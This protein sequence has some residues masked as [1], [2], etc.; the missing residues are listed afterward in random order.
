M[1]FI[2]LLVS[3]F[4]SNSRVSAAVSPVQLKCENRPHPL[5][6]DIAAPRLSWQLTSD[7]RNVHQSAF[8]V[9]VASSPAL[10]AKN[11]G[12]LWNSGQVKSNQNLWVPYA[13]KPLHSAQQ[14]FW[15][16][17]SWDSNARVS[18]WSV[19]GQWT[20][21]LLASTDW[22]AKWITAPSSASVTRKTIGYHAGETKQQ[23]DLK[24]VQVDLGK[25]LAIQT[26]RLH[27]MNHAD[28]AGFGFPL[29]F[30]VEAANNADF[31]NAT[32][33]ADQT[34]TDF[35]NPGTTP[36]GFDGKGVVARFVRVTVPKLAPHPNGVNFAFALSQLEVVS[37]G[38]NV[39]LDAPVLAKDSVENYGWG[40][41]A[42]TDGTLNSSANEAPKKN[43]TSVLLRKELNIKVGLRRA[44]VYVCGL[45][46]YEMTLNGAKV[47]T[48]L[49]APGWTKYDKTCLYDTHDITSQLKM[50]SNAVGLFLG[51]GM[52]NVT[53]GRYS[54]FT[55][56]FGPLKAIAQIRLEYIDGTIQT[57]GTDETWRV[58]PG[59]VTFGDPY[60]G[61]DYDARL[62]PRGWNQPGFKAVDWVPALVADGPGGTLKCL[63]VANPPIRAFDVFKPVGT[64]IISPSVTVYDMGQNASIIPRLVVKGAAGTTVRLIPGESVHA[65]GTVDQS[66]SGGPSYWQY[67]LA[68]NGNET[69]FSPFFYRGC[70]YLQVETSAPTGVALPVVESLANVFV[71][72]DSPPIGS[73]S[74][75][76]PLFNRIFPLVKWAQMSNMV[77]VM[78]DCPHRE[79]L[80]WLEED[81]LNG[82]ALRYNFDMSAMFSKMMNDIADSQQPNGFVPTTAPEYPVFG[83]DFRDSPEWSSALLLV[84]QQQLEFNGDAQL[85]DKYYDEMKRYVAYLDSRAHDH[86]VEFGLGDWYDIGPGEPGYSKLTPK[87]LTATAFYFQDALILSQTAKRRGLADEATKYQQLAQQIRVAFNAKF[88]N[89]ATNQYGSGSQA[90]NS[91]PL[92]MGIAD[93]ANRAAILENLVKDVQ[94]KGLTAGDV[95][96]RYLLRALADGGRS[97]V[98]YAMNNQSDKPGYGMQLAKGATSLTEAWDAHASSSQNHFMLGQINE[99]FYHDLAG[100]QSD[101]TG[102]GFQK[103]II[104]PAVVGDLTHAQATYNSPYG[105]IISNWKRTDGKLILNISIPANTTATVYL[106]TKDAAHITESGKAVGQSV[107]VKFL[108]MEKS[109]AVYVVGSGTYDFA[110]PDN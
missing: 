101:P 107:G 90:S 34:A 28:V 97:D 39:A 13:G 69:Y 35:A 2:F 94:Q 52:Y 9:L 7:A 16:V 37:G 22:Q 110:A 23:D 20:M 103:I 45:G 82:P 3:L 57:I 75:S 36:V 79:K 29:R 14:V 46:Q 62:E 72:A 43:Y 102:P 21:G 24:W 27:P 53:G 47:G 67:T 68:G 96:Y 1:K 87:G 25:P 41:A 73:F 88:F 109:S 85:L 65:N 77:S 38:K 50:G 60:G 26:V 95:G 84:A 48:D 59:P 4:M 98:I 42:L 6:V 5:G 71:H 91:I 33:I 78:T 31:Q 104:K 108:R 92:V 76:N 44:V 100:I 32:L 40:K 8:Q 80:G 18:P 83:G 66:S 54:K 55:G 86:I 56:S 89:P 12:D 58:A 49:L 15:K 30:K 51:N 93:E 64:K 17:R 19:T 105:P 11:Q 70:R 10:L 63:S 99:W 61:E 81:H 106:P 74:T